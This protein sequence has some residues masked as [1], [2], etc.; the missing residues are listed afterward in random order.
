MILKY[1]LFLHH[2]LVETTSALPAG[3]GSRGVYGNCCGRAKLLDKYVI[4]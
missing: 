1:L 2:L 4:R 3:L